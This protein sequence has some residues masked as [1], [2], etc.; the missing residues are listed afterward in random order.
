MP[1]SQFRVEDLNPPYMTLARPT[2]RSVPAQIQFNSR[3]DIGI[4]IPDNLRVSSVKVVLMDLGFSSHAF[5]SSSWLVFMEAELSPDHR[6]ILS[7]P[8][9]RVYPPG[10]AS[11]YVTVGDITS[12]GAH[13]MVGNERALPVEDQ[14]IIL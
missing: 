5:H 12:A 11:M 2:L 10:P 3:F 6:S 7:P 8:N 9:N 13:V 1:K 14:G 4:H